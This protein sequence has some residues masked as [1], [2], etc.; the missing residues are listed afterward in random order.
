[1][2]RRTGEQLLQPQLDRVRRRRH[3]LTWRRAPTMKSRI[4]RR[5]LRAGALAAVPTLYLPEAASANNGRLIPPGK[6]GGITCP[7][8]DGPSRVGIAASAALG[9]A[10]TV[11]YLG[12]R[13]FPRGPD[14]LGPLVPL[15]GG[16]RGLLHYLARLF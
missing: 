12:G 3:R 10:P 6:L 13:D 8:R 1:R 7:Q 2:A 4:T 11:G 16:W 15:P 14:D 5:G 9:V